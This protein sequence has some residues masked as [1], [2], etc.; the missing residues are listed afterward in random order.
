MVD[1]TGNVDWKPEGGQ[2]EEPDTASDRPSVF[3]A[4][5]EQLGLKLEPRK[6]SLDVLMVDAAN[7]A[8]TE[9]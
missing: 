4:L 3:S 7:K 5:P 9:N 2:Q 8:P 6:V 1:F